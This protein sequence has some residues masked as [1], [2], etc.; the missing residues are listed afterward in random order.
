MSTNDPSRQFRSFIRLQRVE[1]FGIPSFPDRGGFD[2]IQLGTVI[3]G[4]LATGGL[5]LVRSLAWARGQGCTDARD[6]VPSPCFA[7]PSSRKAMM[8]AEMTLI[9][10]YWGGPRDGRS[11][12]ITR[13]QALCD[14][15]YIDG[16]RKPVGA[17]LPL[18][19]CIDLGV[20]V[21]HPPLIPVTPRPEWLFHT[22]GDEDWLTLPASADLL[23]RPH[24]ILSND[25]GLR[26]WY[27]DAWRISETEAGFARLAA[28][29]A[30]PS[31]G[32][33]P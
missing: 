4:A 32:D 20:I 18:L 2:L 3:V 9:G 22:A 30:D 16:V 1:W 31:G 19:A 13:R 7:G 12:A 25:P 26:I 10:S 27:P 17:V 29:A 8:C 28:D 14:L 33:R 6:F 23:R 21:D 5:D 24:L 15:W 11:V